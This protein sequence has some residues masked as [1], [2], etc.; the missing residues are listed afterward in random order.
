MLGEYGM[1][2]RLDV[3]EKWVIGLEADLDALES[4]PRGF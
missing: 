1:L 4:P 3:D 2:I